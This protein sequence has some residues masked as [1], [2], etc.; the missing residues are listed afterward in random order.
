MGEANPEAVAL[1]KDIIGHEPQYGE[2]SDGQQCLRV[3]D[4]EIVATSFALWSDPS[5]YNHENGMVS[6]YWGG[7]TIRLY[8]QPDGSWTAECLPDLLA[9]KAR[10]ET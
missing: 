4:I 10:S 3:G 5:V 9:G 1:N 2:T 6:I 7:Q 8:L